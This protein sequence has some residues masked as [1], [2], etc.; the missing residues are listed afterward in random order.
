MNNY[1]K[2][3]NADRNPLLEDI[4]E[5]YPNMLWEVKDSKVFAAGATGYEFVHIVPLIQI[6]GETDRHVPWKFDGKID[7]FVVFKYRVKEVT[8]EEVI[9]FSEMYFVDLL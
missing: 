9:K 3:V 5:I 2:I 4:L 8:S 1:V 7:P 6:S